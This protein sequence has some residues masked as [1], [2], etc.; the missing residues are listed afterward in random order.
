[1]KKA[2][3]L[4][5]LITLYSVL[6]TQYSLA[7]SLRGQALIDSL[8]AELPNAKADT[9]HVKLLS[10]L[11][12]KLIVINPD[13]GIEYGEKA[14][15][16]A[17]KLKW[18]EGKARTYNS[19]AGNYWTKS[20]YPKALDYLGKALKILEE[21]GDKSEIPRILTGMGKISNSQ[22]DYPKALEYY[23]RSLKMFEELGDKDGLANSLNNIGGIYRNQ[24]DYPKAIKF[25]KKALKINE[26]LDK[27]TRV[28]E[29]LSNLGT[30]YHYQ[31]DYPKALEYYGKALKIH[32][33]YGNKLGIA[34]SLGNMGA[35]Y[36]KQSDYPKALE[37][38][39]KA[40]KI[41][42]EIGYKK[43][44]AIN[45]GNMGNIYSEKKDYPKALE[46]YEKALKINEDI[47]NT[48]GV[49]NNLVNMGAIYNKQS[50]YPKAL[51]YYE[52]AFQIFENNGNKSGSAKVLGN[53]GKLYLNL[54][55][56][57]I[58]LNPSEV[59]DFISFNKTINLNKSINYSQKAIEIFD[60][61]G[62]TFDVITILKNLAYAYEFKGDHKK[63]ADALEEHYN[64]KDSIFNQ[65]NQK[66]IDEISTERDQIEAERQAEKE[67]RLQAEKISRRNNIQYL[68][69]SMIL[70]FLGFIMMLNGK[71][72]MPEWLA[73]SLVFVTFILLFE[74]ILVVIDPITD[75]YSEGEPLVKLSIN[76]V[77]AFILYPMHQFFSRKVTTR[78]IKR[79]GGSSIEKI[80]NELKK[81]NS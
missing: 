62:S 40:L 30:I 44:I 7:Q 6:G 74:F 56:D 19:L 17:E 15:Q 39:E 10:S 33:E 34:G 13:K 46:Y 51:E 67:A 73:R 20:N 75:D 50:D 59:N 21:L 72:Q 14:I 37:Y 78:L 2:I 8:V 65:E 41:N 76:L 32:E 38:Y 42:E 16:L 9:N 48:N 49:A 54:S 24:S 29:C 80:L 60:E 23:N 25:F 63:R 71:I 43:G 77:I 36:N 28:A 52:K 12:H 79:G 1:M 3:K 4:I 61:I 27:K 69:I 58:R 18:K 26:K 22:S 57:T 11:S 70:L 68:T 53:M 45:L 81:E 35:I 66:K 47:G 31:S 55:Q 5:L 64:L